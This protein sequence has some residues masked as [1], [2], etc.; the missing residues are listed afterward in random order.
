M[1]IMKKLTMRDGR[2][3]ESTTLFFVRVTWLVM[4]IKFLGSG[5]VISGVTLSPD[6]NIADFGLAVSAVLA[7]WL[8]REWTEK[9]VEKTDE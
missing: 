1:T 5:V 3:R 7:I 4:T 9:Q 6:I 2:G 8:G